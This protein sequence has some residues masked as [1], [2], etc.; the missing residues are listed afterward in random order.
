MGPPHGLSNG[1]PGPP[2]DIAPQLG[3]RG[4]IDRTEYVRVL[5]QALRALG[6]E[7]V[8][9]QLEAASGIVQQPPA[10]AAFRRAVLSGDFDDALRLLP[11][12]AADE[13]VMDRAKFL[14]LKQKYMEGVQRGHTAEALQVL[15]QELQPLRVQQQVLHSLAALL[16]RSPAAAGAAG[17][18]GSPLAPAG[19]GT[20]SGDSAG[21]VSP[22]QL[23]AGRA[24]LLDELQDSLMPSLLIPERRLEGLVEQA[25]ASQLDHSK[26]HNCLHTRLSLFTDYQAGAEQLPT[27]PSQVLEEHSSEVWCIAFSLDGRWAASASK[28]GTALLWSVTSSGRLEDPRLLLRQPVPCQLVA[29]SPDSQL[30]LTASLDSS[31]RLHEVASARQLRQFPQGQE[32]VVALS[33]FPGSQ[34]FLVATHKQLSVLSISGAPH[35]RLPSPHSY[36][37]DAVVGPGGTCILSVGQDRKIAFQRL[38]DQRVELVGESGTVTS[39]SLSPCQHFLTTNLAD[40]CVHLWQLPPGLGGQQGTAGGPSRYVLRSC[41]GGATSGFVA[42][43]AEDCRL[44]LWSRH[45][46]DLLECLAGHTGCINA[47]AWHPRMPHLI[48]SASDDGTI[49]TWMAAAAMKGASLG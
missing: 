26:Y 39:M 7:E 44:Y 35:Q 18:M 31:V 30:I 13:G 2:T 20:T 48:A 5:E 24:A 1:L 14:L 17:M 28:D 41:V 11:S 29:F 36:V 32:A 10:A 23:A 37:Y 19:A 21:G 33:W 16:L 42:C 22:E 45:S 27:E 6:Y 25:L 3:R 40:N 34:L 12:V 43:G 4:L 47:V 46:G 9:A 8:A 15:R 38:S 49:R